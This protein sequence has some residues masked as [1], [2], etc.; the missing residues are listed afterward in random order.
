[1]ELKLILRGNTINL[2]EVRQQ[3]QDYLGKLSSWE[4]IRQ[5]HPVLAL[6]LKYN[7]RNFEEAIVLIHINPNMSPTQLS[8]I[9]SYTFTKERLDI[10]T[11]FFLRDI[12]FSQTK[13]RG[14]SW[15]GSDILSMRQFSA[16]RSHECFGLLDIEYGTNGRSKDTP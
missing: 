3:A 4:N 10:V 6:D 5:E 11:D 9:L 7:K 14:K 13:P 16:R 8:A 1:M 2:L 15:T 12:L